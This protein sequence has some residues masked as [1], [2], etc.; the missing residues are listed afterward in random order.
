MFYV[1]DNPDN[2]RKIR[3]WSEWHTL[4]PALEQ[5]PNAHGGFAIISHA[6]GVAGLIVVDKVYPVQSVLDWIE[7]GSIR[8]HDRNGHKPWE[9][10]FDVPEAV[11]LDLQSKGFEFVCVT[12]DGDADGFNSIHHYNRP[13]AGPIDLCLA[14][15]KKSQL[16]A[17]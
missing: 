1:I 4:A 10:I 2:C 12:E 5:L 17:G 6:V 14:K 3:V 16:A 13:T 11:L 8:R 7:R 15:L 9:T